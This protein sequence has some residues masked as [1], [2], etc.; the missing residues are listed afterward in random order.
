V[1]HSYELLGGKTTSTLVWCTGEFR[2]EN[3]KT[4]AA[5]MAALREA[6][7]IIN[8]DKRAAAEL[9][10]RMTNGKESLDNMEKILSHRD[11]EYTLTPRSMV[12]YADFMHQTGSIKVK[13]ESWKD[14]FFPEVYELP[15]S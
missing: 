13:P 6:T 4:Y 14:M 5:I 8:R 9:Y 1:V 11:I 15:G 3:P 10:L 12:K 7:D 2:R